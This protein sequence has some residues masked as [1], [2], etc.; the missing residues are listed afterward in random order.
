MG[1]TATTGRLWRE[2]IGEGPKN[3]GDVLPDHPSSGLK[4]I[5]NVM[6]RLLLLDIP[7]TNMDEH[8]Q[9]EMGLK[10]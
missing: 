3:S 2:A 5:S 8:G 7:S 1:K 9:G 4:G 6:L 10:H